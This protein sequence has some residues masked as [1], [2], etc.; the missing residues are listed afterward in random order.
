MKTEISISWEQTAG[1]RHD[2][3]Q[4][5]KTQTAKYLKPV[6]EVTALWPTFIFFKFVFMTL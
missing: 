4:N 2:S 5:L 6:L 1:A 3:Q